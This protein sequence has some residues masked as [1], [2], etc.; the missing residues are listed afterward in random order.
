NE[1]YYTV[2]SPRQGILQTI[3]FRRKLSTGKWSEPEIASFSN[4]FSNLEPAFSA[5]GKTIYFCSN[6]PVSGDKPKDFD[7][8]MAV[9][10]ASGWDPPVN[11]GAPINTEKDEFYPSIT[12]EG[13]LYFTATYKDGI[14]LEDIYVARR[15]DGIYQKPVIIDSNVNSR[16]YEFNAFV[17]PDESFIL[18]TSYGRKDD[19]GGG[20][21]YISKRTSSGGWTPAKNLEIINSN[22]LDYCPYVSPDGN[23]LFFTSERHTIETKSIDRLS[24]K[25]LVAS[26]NSPLNGLGNIWWISMA[27]VLKE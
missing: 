1:L 14:G 27:A 15:T 18:F 16:G 24:Y 17:S 26:F 22:K 19:Q 13:N 20:D 2:Q 9:R 21:L 6:R 4:A 10:T 11:L 5:D 25:Q 23:I 12:K 7:I 3:L 8:W